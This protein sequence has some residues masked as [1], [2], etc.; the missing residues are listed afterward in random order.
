MLEQ[1]GGFGRDLPVVWVR[2]AA[3]LIDLLPN[4]VD[5]CRVVVLLCLC[6]KPLAF[7]EHDLLLCG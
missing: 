4:G 1:T 7:V 6:G 2:Q 5:D 3:P